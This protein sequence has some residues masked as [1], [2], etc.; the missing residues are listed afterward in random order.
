RGA[1]VLSGS[2]LD[3]GSLDPAQLWPRLLILAGNIA[4]HAPALLIDPLTIRVSARDA[5][6]TKKV[7]GI[8]VSLPPGKRFDLS[9]DG[10]T[11]AIE[12]D[13]S[14][15][16]GPASA[17]GL[18]I[19]LL[20]IENNT[21]AAVFGISVR[22]VGVRIGKSDGP[23]L[24]T[25]LV[26]DTVAVHGLVTVTTD[27]GVTDAGGQLELGNM[28]ISLGDAGGGN[29]AVAKGVMKDSASGSEKPEPRF[30]PALAVQSHGGGPPRFDLRAGEG[31]GPWWMTIQH[32][33]GPVYIE[34]VGF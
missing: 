34:Q 16:T 31:D 5:S 25:Y 22:G 2:D 12:V 6:A 23:L 1:S 4:G 21:P 3:S 20:S 33:F 27:D 10:V 18:V 7:Y 15:I 29:N 11:V 13:P 32:G 14:W 19:E 9:T 17:D 28:H 8:A 30:S 26:L 24:D